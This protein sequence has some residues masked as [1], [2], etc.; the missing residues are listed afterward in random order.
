M[1]G[2]E[3]ICKWPAIAAAPISGVQDVLFS[4]FLRPL[5]EVCCSNEPTDGARM[6]I[7]EVLKSEAAVL[8]CVLRNRA[9]S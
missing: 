1:E 9:I 5:R 6:D 8:D 3:Q 4:W 7:A 2:R